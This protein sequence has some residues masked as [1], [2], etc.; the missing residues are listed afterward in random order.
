MSVTTPHRQANS[1]TNERTVN[2]LLDGELL[3]LYVAILIVVPVAMLLR[4][5]WS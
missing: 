4:S 1:R 3:D 2:R 5:L